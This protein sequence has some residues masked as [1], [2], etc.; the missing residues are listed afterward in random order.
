VLQAAVAAILC[1][2]AR[3]RCGVEVT[4]LHAVGQ[5]AALDGEEWLLLLEVKGLVVGVLVEAEDAG[6]HSEVKVC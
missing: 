5:D 6:K 3:I 4:D 2:V 1:L